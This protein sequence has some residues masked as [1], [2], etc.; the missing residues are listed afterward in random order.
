MS[1][2]AFEELNNLCIIVRNRN[3]DVDNVMA[4]MNITTF[5]D[6]KLLLIHRADT[7]GKR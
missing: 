5:I 7:Q 6:F 4:Q 3:N 1:F 2:N